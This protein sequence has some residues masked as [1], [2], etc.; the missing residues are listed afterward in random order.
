MRSASLES[1][2]LD[3]AIVGKTNPYLSTGIVCG[4][5]QELGLEAVSID[6]ASGC[7]QA[8]ITSGFSDYQTLR[9]RT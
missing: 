3:K 9:Y 8:Q 4:V 1:E 7:I 6:R 5:K 2:V